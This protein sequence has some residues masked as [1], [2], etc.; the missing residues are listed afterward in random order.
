VFTKRISIQRSP[1]LHTLISPEQ[2]GFLSGQQINE[3]II[4]IQEA[5][6]SSSQ[7]KEKG[8]VIKLDMANAF[9]KVRHS[10]LHKVLAKFGFHSHFIQWIQACM[11]GP[12][13]APRWSIGDLQSLWGDPEDYA[14]AALFPPL[15][16]FMAEALG[17]ALEFARISEILLGIRIVKGVKAVNTT[18]FVNDTL[19]IGG[20]SV[21]IATRFKSILDHYLDASIKMVNKA[22]CKVY[23]WNVLAQI[24]ALIVRS[25]EFTAN[26]QIFKY[27]RVPIAKSPLSLTS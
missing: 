9:N 18:Q 6:H 5:V 15:Y 17:R 22:K 12:W 8:L 3:N 21:Q 24:I 19:F 23:G 4:I 13:I 25:L 1:L 20:A 16:M 11:G 10:F 7:A 27:I 26:H 14:K 2:G